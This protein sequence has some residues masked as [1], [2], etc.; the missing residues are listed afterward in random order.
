MADTPTDPRVL[1][2][3]TTLKA[4]DPRLEHKDVAAKI[5]HNLDEH[6]P[7]RLGW[8]EKAGCGAAAVAGIALL[9]MLVLAAGI[10][11]VWLYQA[12]L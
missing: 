1:T 10:G 6:E 4:V 11:V 8:A 12:V 9:A 2:V 3:L 5:V 7:N